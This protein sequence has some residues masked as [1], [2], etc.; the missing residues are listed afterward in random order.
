MHGMG[1]APCPSTAPKY[2]QCNLNTWD[3]SPW[4]IFCL[5]FLQHPTGFAK[6]ALLRCTAVVQCSRAEMLHGKRVITGA[7]AQSVRTEHPHCTCTN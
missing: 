6:W 5:F 1:H 4:F 7:W 3:S 2:S